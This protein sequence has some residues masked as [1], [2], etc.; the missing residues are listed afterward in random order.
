MRNTARLLSVPVL[1]QKAV[2]RVI[3]MIPREYLFI[4]SLLLK[5]S[6]R[7]GEEHTCADSSDDKTYDK[8]KNTNP[9]HNLDIIFF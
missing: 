7:V 8:H 9:L 3:P 4:T 1:M 2:S 6:V 5:L